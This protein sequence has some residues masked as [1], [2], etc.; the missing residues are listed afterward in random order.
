MHRHPA[1]YKGRLLLSFQS[2]LFSFLTYLGTEEPNI[3]SV[4]ENVW[5]QLQKIAQLFIRTSA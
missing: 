1:I 2:D 3:L 4:Y 5:I